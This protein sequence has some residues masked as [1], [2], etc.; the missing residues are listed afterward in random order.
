MTLRKR[1]IDKGVKQIAQ[2][3]QSQYISREKKLNLIKNNSLL[4]KQ[5]KICSQNNKIFVKNIKAGEGFRLLK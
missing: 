5:N 1:K 4:K 2:S 3:E